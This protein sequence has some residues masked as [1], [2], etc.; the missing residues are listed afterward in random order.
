MNKRKMQK[1][2]MYELI[3]YRFLT[4]GICHQY[5]VCV[6]IINNLTLLVTEATIEIKCFFYFNIKYFPYLDYLLIMKGIC[7]WSPDGRINQRM[8]NRKSFQ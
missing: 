1:E 8:S 3:S 5:W 6:C 2:I 7:S 4:L